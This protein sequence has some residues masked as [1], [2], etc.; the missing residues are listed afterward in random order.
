MRHLRVPVSKK[1]RS[2]R[3]RRVGRVTRVREPLQRVRN[4]RPDHPDARMVDAR[5][6]SFGIDYTSKYQIGYK[7]YRLLHLQQY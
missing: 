6:L 1:A 4:P 3:R 2:G 7:W 5:C